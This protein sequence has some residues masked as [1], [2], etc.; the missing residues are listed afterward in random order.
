LYQAKELLSDEHV[1]N[2]HKKKKS[3]SKKWTTGKINYSQ[4]A[5]P[6]YSYKEK[7]IEDWQNKN[8]IFWFVSCLEENFPHLPDYNIVYNKD[9]KNIKVL[10]KAFVNAGY[11]KKELKE[12]IS[13]IVKNYAQDVLDKKEKEGNLPSFTTN[14]LLDFMNPYIQHLEISQNKTSN[15]NKPKSAVS[16]KELD[17]CW[18]ENKMVSL[19]RSYGIPIASTYLYF[20]INDDTATNEQKI[21][22]IIHVIAKTLEKFDSDNL[23]KIAKHSIMRGPYNNDFILLNWQLVFED[24]WKSIE[25]HNQKWWKKIEINNDS[26]WWFS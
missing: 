17:I 2:P 9:G 13:Y 20:K 22:K 10:E 6:K 21:Q 25:I 14:D 4:I 15:F 26:N 23:E 11:G 12:F 24:F 1:G 19:L 7:N 5:E 3:K 18:K 16:K 8:F